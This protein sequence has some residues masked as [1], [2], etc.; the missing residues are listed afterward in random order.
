MR[1]ISKAFIFLILL[2]ICTLGQLNLFSS[3]GTIPTR[4]NSD[5]QTIS[6]RTVTLQ[7]MLEMA[8]AKN[9]DITL[10]K[11]SNEISRF[12][13]R[14]A[15]GFFDPRFVS[16]ATGDKT[17]SPNVSV[18]TTAESTNNRTIAGSLGFQGLMPA[19]GGS[20]NLALSGQRFT[21]DNS[22][23]LLSPQNNANLSFSITQPLLRGLTIDAPRRGLL[24]SRKNQE[25]SDVQLRMKSI[26][27][28]SAVSRAYWDLVFALKNL[29][30]Q[31]TAVGDAKKQLDHNRR[32]VE[33]G[34]LAPVDILAG[35]TQVANLE[36]NLAE[37][38]EI[39]TRA[40]N[41]LKTLVGGGKDD[42]VWSQNLL[43]IDAPDVMQSEIPVA[44]VRR[45]TDTAIG[46]R[47]EIEL[48][49]I[50]ISI[51]D[52]ETRY[53]RNQRLP[54]IDLTASYN[55]GGIGGSPNPGFST[56]FPSPCTTAPTSEACLQQLALLNGLTGNAFDDIWENR[57]PSVKF[58]L[59]FTL[60]VG[61]RTGGAELGKAIVEADRART[62]RAQIEQLI[63]MDVRNAIQGI[64]TAE[65]RLKNAAVARENSEKQYESEQRK[66]DA[67]QSDVYR[68]LERQTA[69]VVAQ[70]AELRAKTELRKAIVEYQRATGSLLSNNDITV[71]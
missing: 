4:V 10:S 20:Y 19:F 37:A 59:T 39:V 65:S 67:G 51:T 8:L 17:R 26:E 44:D 60:P 63:Q 34:Q 2:P 55:S 21:T 14:A 6:Q 58:G 13:A 69:M 49:D 71:K 30:V 45:D 52:I 46:N 16:Q 28:V 57:Y 66:L 27:T 56:P 1:A 38:V 11:Q 23:A 53:F 25:M 61:G 31:K 24:L 9:L 32:L 33:E 3:L 40:E 68:V 41:Y 43:P 5:E 18:F 64:R 62:R 48:S 42:E 47:P 36:Q 22:F 50:E 12:N 35:E 70:S 54:Q 7:E 29:Q 15:K